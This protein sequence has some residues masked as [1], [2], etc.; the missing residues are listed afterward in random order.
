MSGGGFRWY[1][2]GRTCSPF[3][4]S[5]RSVTGVLE[6]FLKRSHQWEKK[7]GFWSHDMILDLILVFKTQQLKQTLHSHNTTHTLV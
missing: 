1:L 7:T 5:V 3:L 2:S 6:E 4:P